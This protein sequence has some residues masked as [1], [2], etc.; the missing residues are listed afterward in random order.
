MT[1]ETPSVAQRLGGDQF[2]ART[3]GRSY[4]VVRGNTASVAGL[5]SWDD[6]NAILTHHRLET[7]RFRLASDGEPV[8]AF[9]YSRPV[10]TRRSTTW[11][12]LQTATLHEQ[13]ADGATLVLDAVDELHPGVGR[14]AKHLENWLRTAVQV[15]LYG[16]WTGTEGFGTHWD[17]HDV[18]V[19]Q[20]DGAKRWKLYG[21]TRTAPMSR[22]VATPEEPPEQPVADLVLTA[23]DVLYLPRGWWHA[24]AA[25]EGRHSLH[26]TCGLQTTTGADL[27]TWLSEI[28]RG[29]EVIRTDVP[30]FGTEGEQREFLDRIAKLVA[31]ELAGPD[32]ITRFLL[33][34]DATESARLAPSLPYVTGI[35]PQPELLVQLVVARPRLAILPDGAPQLTAGGEEWTFTAEA[36]P[37][38]QLL[39]DGSSHSLGKLAAVAGLSVEQVAGAVNG[40]VSGQVAAVRTTL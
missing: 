40:L 9:R 32:V 17:D 19:V 38:L 20:L 30:R 22:D 14:L 39:L 21:P 1:T 2:L 10:V 31:D 33:A 28:L 4:H 37:L 13:L 3:F 11:Q 36:L 26:L 5:V 23:G 7:P 34:R 27:I 24:V 12:R 8:P 16:S 35:P 18:I 15:N 6:L 29:H 25:S